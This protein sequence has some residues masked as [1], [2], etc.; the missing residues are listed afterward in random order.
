MHSFEGDRRY[1]EFTIRKLLNHGVA[2]GI[3]ANE[4]LRQQLTNER[5]VAHLP[6]RRHR[7]MHC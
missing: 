7:A 5:A 4:Y 1:D 2:H 6:S 3:A